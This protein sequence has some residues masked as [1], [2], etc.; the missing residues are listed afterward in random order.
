MR[1]GKWMLMV[2]ALLTAIATA[3]SFSLVTH[4]W[5]APPVTPIS[6]EVINSPLKTGDPV[7]VRFVTKRNKLCR[8]DADLY[9]I[10]LP[11]HQVL[12]RERIPAISIPLGT[13]TSQ[14][15]FPRATNLR[16]NNDLF[17]VLSPGSYIFREFIHSDCG[18]GNG[19][20][21]SVQTPDAPFEVIP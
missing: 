18:N 2:V 8:A 20:Y 17:P 12:W 14:V 15:S 9:V 16:G 7:I 4:Y 6:M 5:S 3:T 21:S 1:N 19:D 10:K 13:G 11:E